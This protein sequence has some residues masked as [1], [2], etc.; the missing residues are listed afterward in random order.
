VEDRSAIMS[1]SERRP[2]SAS[3][4][5]CEASV[6]VPSTRAYDPSHFFHISECQG[7]F[8]QVFYGVYLVFTDFLVFLFFF[9]T[10]FSKVLSAVIILS[11]SATI[12]L[13]RSN[14]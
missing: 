10:Y 8:S 2:T 5:Q 4:C 11:R 9:V 3:G 7:M 12:L 13:R 6:Q 1:G 14:V